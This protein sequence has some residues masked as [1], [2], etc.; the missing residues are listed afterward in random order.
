M[1]GRPDHDSNAGPTARDTYQ[2]DRIP[3]A[4]TLSAASFT[5][6]A[7]RIASFTS[8]SEGPGVS[9]LGY[10]KVLRARR[11]LLN[12]RS[13]RMLDPNWAMT[14]SCTATSHFPAHPVSSSLK[15][16]ISG[17]RVTSA[18]KPSVPSR[19]QVGDRIVTLTSR[20]R[21]LAAR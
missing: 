5:S 17:R 9:V 18:W 21:R 12:E 1:S 19:H 14:A 10:S 6:R 16:G 15:T 3:F 11:S 13:A 4:S 20:A 8:S 2:G 7:T